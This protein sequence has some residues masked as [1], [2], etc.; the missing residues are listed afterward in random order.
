VPTPTHGAR[1]LDAEGR[2]VFKEILKLY[3]THGFPI[4]YGG[5]GFSLY[6]NVDGSK[7]NFLEGYGSKAAE[8]QTLTIF[9]TTITKNIKKGEEIA[10]TFRQK[11][12]Q[13]GIFYETK[14]AMKYK[15]D[16]KTDRNAD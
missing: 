10:K 11:L 1:A 4:N 3:E 12:R 2:A 7:V 13:T 5:K 15:F 9:F 14:T 6:G 16:K 8:G